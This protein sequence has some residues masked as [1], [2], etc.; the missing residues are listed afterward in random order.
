VQAPIPG[1]R[2]SLTHQVSTDLYQ[3]H[4]DAGSGTCVTCGHATPC[5]AQQ[6]ATSVIT[7]AGEDPHS[8][9]TRSPHWTDPSVDHQDGE[10]DRREHQPEPDVQTSP[11]HTGYH[12]G[13]RNR[14]V[15]PQGFSYDRDSS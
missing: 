7:A 1:L 6:H 15:H 14:P 13:G 2:G 9:D 3:R 4:H 5:P 11:T 10:A 8:Y 12:L